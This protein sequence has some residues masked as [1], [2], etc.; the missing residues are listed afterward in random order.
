MALIP[1]SRRLVLLTAVLVLASLQF[2]GAYD[3]LDPFG[4]ITVKWDIMAWTGDGYTAV[5]SM[6]NTQQFR[7]IEKYHMGWTWDKKEVIY[8]MQGGQAT[9]QGDCTAYPAPPPHS[10]VRT[11]D[12]VDLVP[13]VP[14][15]Q[16][17]ANC[18]RDGAISAY[19]QD[20]ANSVSSFQLTVGYAGNTNTTVKM[21]LKLTL[22]SPGPGYTCSDLKKVAPTRFSQSNGRFTQAYLTWNAT[23]TY[24]QYLAQKAPTCCVSLSAFYSTD[25]VKCPDCACNCSPNVTG[26]GINVLPGTDQTCI[27]TQTNYKNLPQLENGITSNGVLATPPSLYCTNDMCPVKVHWHIKENYVNY[28]RAKVTVTNR[29]FQKNYSDWNIVVQHENFVNFS[30]AF[31]FTYKALTPY[32]DIVNDTAMFWGVDYYN[33]MLLQAGPDGNVQSEL[34]FAKDSR[35]TWSNGWG[36]PTRIYFNGD[37][38]VLPEPQNYPQLPNDG[39]KARVGISAALSLLMALVLAIYLSL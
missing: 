15:S 24:S 18:C 26:P 38:C 32:G 36:F 10:C 27:S 13:G 5:V 9:E 37:D 1:G 16:Q 31:S 21:P 34:L 11:P 35:F 2:T 20:P 19:A 14:Y 4:A 22:K 7:G 12:I 8:V 28:W 39:H 25:I 17:V 3:P 30:E 29:N 23:C 6:Y 33:Q